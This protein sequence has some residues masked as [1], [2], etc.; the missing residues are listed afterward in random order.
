MKSG[1]I[2]FD[3]LQRMP[4]AWPLLVSAIF[5]VRVFPP[6]PC[7]VDLVRIERLDSL[8]ETV[9]VWDRKLIVGRSRTIVLVDPDKQTF[10]DGSDRRAVGVGVFGSYD[11]IDQII[12]KEAVY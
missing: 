2:A 1:V 8:L 12:H 9:S 10:I 11:L 4:G 5:R 3:A 6:M 7:A